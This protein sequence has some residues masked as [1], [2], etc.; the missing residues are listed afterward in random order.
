MTRSALSLL[1]VLAVAAGCGGGAEQAD[2]P[3]ATTATTVV[4]I[5]TTTTAAPTTTTEATTTTSTTVPEPTTTTAPPPDDTLESGEEG[6]E[7]L[8]LQQRLVELGYWLGE[9]DGRYGSLTSQ[10]VL[11]FQKYHGLGR[12]GVAG[13]ATQAALATAAR[14]TPQVGGTGIEIDLERQVLLVVQDGQV[15]WALNTSTGRSGWRTHAGTFTIERQ[16]DGMR[17]APLGDLWRPK[18]FNGGQ[19]I[20]GSASIPSQPASHGCARLSNPAIDML[21]S[22]GL[23]E[24][25]TAVSVY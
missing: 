13:P 18:Y 25:G 22:S 17:H 10:A 8:A 9:P 19:A 6:P 4:E 16:I 5:V 7:V 11:A 1:L 24:I 14:P 2:D 20:H 12:D 15:T 21:W 23:A 3:T